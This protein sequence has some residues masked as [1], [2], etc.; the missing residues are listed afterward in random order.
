VQGGHTTNVI[1]SEVKLMGTFRTMDESWRFK[2]HE[3]IEQQARS[4]AAGM[5]ADIDLHIDVGYPS[6]Y[7]HETLNAEA[8]RLAEEFIGAE[9]VSE[10]ELRMGAEDFGYYS[11]VIPGCFYRLGTGNMEKGISAGVHTPTFNIDENA[12]PIGMGMMAW[13]GAN[14]KMQAS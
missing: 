7:N 11:Q 14:A 2:A 8:R 10:T 12:I 3:L 1:P 13:L 4:I 9:H 6:V 5:G